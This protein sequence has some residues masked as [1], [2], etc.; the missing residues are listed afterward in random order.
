V[1]TLINLKDGSTK[2]INL[3][4][5]VT[6]IFYAGTG[7]LLISNP[8]SLILYDLQQD[9]KVSEIL[10]SNVRNVCW[11]T[12]NSLLAILSK[13]GICVFKSSNYNH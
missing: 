6:E 7:Y 9:I 8:S 2:N 1:I 12:D 13:H 11:S 10:V 5:P 4:S 3:S